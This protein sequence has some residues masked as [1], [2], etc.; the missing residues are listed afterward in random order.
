M[1]KFIKDP[2]KEDGY[3]VVKVEWGRINIT[4]CEYTES[5]K[6]YSVVHLKDRKVRFVQDAFMFTLGNPILD[7]LMWGAKIE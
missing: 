3:Y 7:G 6:P 2:P 5:F 1:M 4:K